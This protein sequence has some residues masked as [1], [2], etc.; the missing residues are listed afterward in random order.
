MLDIVNEYTSEVVALLR[1]SGNREGK[2]RKSSR[3]FAETM[4]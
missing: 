3:I 4:Q 2:R 1:D